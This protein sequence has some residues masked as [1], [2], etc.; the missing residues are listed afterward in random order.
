MVLKNATSLEQISFSCITVTVWTQDFRKKGYFIIGGNFLV[1][2][3]M[4]VQVS[5]HFISNV[6]SWFKLQFKRVHVV[7]KKDSNVI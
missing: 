1:L 4:D 2:I 3:R 5:E 7:G 6:V